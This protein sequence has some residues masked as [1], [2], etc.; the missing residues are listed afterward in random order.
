[1]STGLIR[2][3]PGRSVD[4]AA[5]RARR[6]RR[7]V[8][9]DLTA[10]L[11]LALGSAFMDAQSRVPIES[12]SLRN[13]GRVEAHASEDGDRWVGAMVWGGPSA[14]H[15]VDYAIYAMGSQPEN[16]WLRGSAAYEEALDEVIESH[17]RRLTR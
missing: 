12:G 16:D 4:E 5:T 11:D 1:M 6:M 8:T 3:R 9:P 13:S 15:D 10:E 7:V 17:L 14:P 2:E